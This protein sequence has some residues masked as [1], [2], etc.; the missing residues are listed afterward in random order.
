MSR[1]GATLMQAAMK[2][3]LVPPEELRQ[4]R[5]EAHRAFD[6][7]WKG[8]R[9]SRSQAYEWMQRTMKL[10]PHEAH[11]SLFSREQCAALCAAMVAA[12]DSA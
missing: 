10:P 7:L 4:A 8:G 6:Q 12:G 9:M 2:Q 11:I 3:M 1:R 5:Y